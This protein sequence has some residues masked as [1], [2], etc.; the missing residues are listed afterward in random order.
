[1][2]ILKGKIKAT[3]RWDY[4]IKTNNQI[5]VIETNFYATQCS[6]LNET[7]RSYELIA[8]KVKKINGLTF[9]WI[10]DGVGWN[11]AKLPLD[12]TF[13]VLDTLYNIDDLDNGILNSLK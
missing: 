5:Y 4:V 13:N 3:K 8:N 6:K 11:N 1:M 10:T 2:S 9:I 12:E 7:A